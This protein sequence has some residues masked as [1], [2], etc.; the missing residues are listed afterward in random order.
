MFEV[1]IN[2]KSS[3]LQAN[4]GICQTKTE[5]GAN[6]I[7]PKNFVTL[8]KVIFPPLIRRDQWRGK[9]ETTLGRSYRQFQR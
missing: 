3:D 9:S 1:K 4:R 8:R 5:R 2:K 7:R 6:Q